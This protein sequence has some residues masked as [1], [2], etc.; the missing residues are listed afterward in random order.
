MRPRREIAVGTPRTL[1]GASPKAVDLWCWAAV[2][3]DAAS[4]LSYDPG[5]VARVL[6]VTRPRLRALERELESR[7]LFRIETLSRS[8]RRVVVLGLAPPAITCH[9]AVQ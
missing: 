7:E 2:R 9:E 6:E 1:A 4:R 8:E 3:G 5:Y